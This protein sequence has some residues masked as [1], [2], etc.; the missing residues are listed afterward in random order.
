M[1]DCLHTELM[2]GR[3][4]DEV[5]CGICRAPLRANLSGGYEVNQLRL[6]FAA[7][8]ATAPLPVLDDNIEYPK[9]DIPFF[10]FN[11]QDRT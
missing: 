8:W 11:T 2:P 3:F 9:L 10:K 1:S 6:R 4:V 5:W 7:I